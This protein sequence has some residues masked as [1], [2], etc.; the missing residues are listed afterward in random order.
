MYSFLHTF[1]KL[2]SLLW[3]FQENLC[4]CS[5]GMD[6]EAFLKKVLK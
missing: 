1:N 3:D 2:L 6:G 4:L 5:I